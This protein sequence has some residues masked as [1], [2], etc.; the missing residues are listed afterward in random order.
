[1]A[2]LSLSLSLS[3]FLSLFFSSSRDVRSSVP[4]VF[5][6]RNETKA[7]FKKKEQ[8]LLFA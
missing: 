6:P 3:L 1:M 2:T 7:F 4:F 5:F 8:Q